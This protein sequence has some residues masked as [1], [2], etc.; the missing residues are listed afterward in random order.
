M[1][2]LVVSG[3]APVVMSLQRAIQSPDGGG[4]GLWKRQ[5]KKGALSHDGLTRGLFWGRS[6][7]I[8]Y[9]IAF[10][11]SGKRDPLDHLL[12]DSNGTTKR[13]EQGWVQVPMAWITKYLEWK[14]TRF[15][16][17]GLMLLPS[18]LIVPH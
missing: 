9:S 5:S 2:A 4:S 13:I 8:G 1:M 17:S 7:S 14:R 10:A 3:L 18:G 11:K 12:T 6:G 16:L 15:C